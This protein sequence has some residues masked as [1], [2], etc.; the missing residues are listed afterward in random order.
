ML[1]CGFFKHLWL[2][3]PLSQGRFLVE[4]VT[5]TFFAY[6][7]AQPADIHLNIVFMLLKF[8]SSEQGHSCVFQ[9]LLQI[10]FQNF[11][12]SSR[13]WHIPNG[14]RLLLFFTMY[15]TL[16]RGTCK[17]CAINLQKI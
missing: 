17:L 4:S 7:G 3:S 6:A 12:W 5:N 13:S 1:S 2:T 11:W 9:Q 10:S 14:P 16:F 15:S 8:L